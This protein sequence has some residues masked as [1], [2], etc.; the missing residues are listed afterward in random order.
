MCSHT[1]PTTA[2]PAEAFRGPN[3][4]ASGKSPS[5]PSA[6]KPQ[7]R[8][9]LR[10]LM[11]SPEPLARATP[12]PCCHALRRAKY[13]SMDLSYAAGR[14]GGSMTGVLSAGNEQAVEVRVRAWDRTQ[15]RTAAFRRVRCKG[16]SAWALAS[17]TLCL[18]RSTWLPA[19]TSSSA[20]CARVH[21]AAW[22]V[23]CLVCCLPGVPECIHVQNPELGPVLAC[24]CAAAWSFGA[25]ACQPLHRSHGGYVSVCAPQKL[26]WHAKAALM[27]SK[28]GCMICCWML[29]TQTTGVCLDVQNYRSDD[30]KILLT[31]I[32]S[33]AT[34]RNISGKF[35]RMAGEWIEITAALGACF[36]SS[37]ATAMSCSARLDS[38]G[39][40]CLLE[41][42]AEACVACARRRCS[43][44]ARSTTWTSS[45]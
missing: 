30:K 33:S 25:T 39:V 11:G 36:R 2:P 35:A 6:C 43:W 17:S 37:A 8:S 9:G 4:F 28:H 14:I 32:G 5:D 19:L 42:H 23:V 16:T 27:P 13:P 45:P 3:H 12:Q 15:R 1:L 22:C 29:C 7:C 34:K 41:A 44:M 38:L 26:P 21:S 20:W 31:Q 18:P 10:T 24:F 40:A